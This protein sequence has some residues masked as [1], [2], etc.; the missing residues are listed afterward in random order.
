MKPC[1]EVRRQLRSGT[2]LGP[3]EEQHLFAC[4]PC[5]RR[6]RSERAERE[7]E[8]LASWGPSAAAVAPDFVPRVMRGLPLSSAR[9][10]RPPVSLGKWAAALAVFSAAAG[11]GYTVGAD[12]AAAGQQ[13][14][15]VSPSSGEEI[16]SFAF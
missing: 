8:S 7:I 16:A 1:R 5:R 10:T 13:V 2:G 12:T 15:A 14:A 11:Y 3:G 6:A 9:R 4:P